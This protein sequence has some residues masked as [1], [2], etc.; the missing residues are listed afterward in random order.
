MATSIEH[1]YVVTGISIDRSRI[2]PR[3]IFWSGDQI[4]VHGTQ[5]GHHGRIA[6]FNS[7]GDRRLSVTFKDSLSGKFVEYTDAVLIPER[8]VVAA[9][10]TPARLRAGH[11]NN[12][13]SSARTPRPPI[14]VPRMTPGVM[15]TAIKE[16]PCVMSMCLHLNGVYATALIDNMTGMPLTRHGVVLTRPIHQSF[17]V[18]KGRRILMMTTQY[19]NTMKIA[20]KNK[21]SHQRLQ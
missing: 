5:T 4:Q 9:M 14:M 3:D 21:I 11:P 20:K 19:S 15:R 13:T 1:R 7:V 6:R 17:W 12:V 2:H 10:P 8:T 16:E 18:Y